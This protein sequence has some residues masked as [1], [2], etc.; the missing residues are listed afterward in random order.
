MSRRDVYIAKFKAQIDELNAQMSQAKAKALEAKE[1]V[2][3]KYNEEI[4]RLGAQ[5]R[6]ASAKLE[7]LKSAGEDHWEA[8]VGEVEKVGDA[9][10]SSF[11]NFMSRF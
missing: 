3:D 8:L 5:T 7:E 9:L 1:D 2:R 4:E 6:Q 10:K 11:N